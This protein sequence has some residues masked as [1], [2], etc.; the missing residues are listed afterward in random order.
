MDDI[1]I[2]IFDEI[3]NY[4]EKIYFFNFRQWIFSLLIVATVIP[5][6]LLLK[7]RIGEEIT[8]YIVIIEAAVIGF[9]GF[10]KIH[11]LQAEK[12]LPY[13]FR[14]YFCFGKV[15]PYVS[16]E[17][18]ERQHQRRNKKRVKK[19]KEEKT[20]KSEKQQIKQQIRKQKRQQKLLNKAKK[21]YK[22]VVDENRKELVIPKIEKEDE[23]INKFSKLSKE[24]QEAIFKLLER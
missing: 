2:I 13:W 12:I 10:A 23:L 19:K 20:I 14:H 1:E 6:Y 4:K 18:Y 7:Q 11:E 21:K 3:N 9:I 16:E 22:V 17:E 15:I 24:Q 5:T 8:S